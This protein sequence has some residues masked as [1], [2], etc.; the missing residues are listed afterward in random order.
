MELATH[1][2]L[3][4]FIQQSKDRE[5]LIPEKTIWKVLVQILVGLNQIRNLGLLHCDL[6]PSNVLLF[7]LFQESPKTMKLEDKPKFDKLVKLCDFNS[8]MKLKTRFM[9]SPMTTPLYMSPDSIEGLRAGTAHDLWSLG[10]ILYEMCSLNLPFE[11]E[12][13]PSLYKNICGSDYPS[14]P[15]KYSKDLAELINSLLKK[16]PSSRPTLED[17]L[18]NNSII[19]KV[20][21]SLYKKL[22]LDSFESLCQVRVTEPG[23]AQQQDLIFLDFLT[24]GKAGKGTGIEKFGFLYAQKYLNSS[25]KSLKPT[26]K[27]TFKAGSQAKPLKTG[28]PLRKKSSSK[29]SDFEAFELVLKERTDKKRD[30]KEKKNPYY[31]SQQEDKH[32]IMFD[33]ELM[34]ASDQNLASLLKRHQVNNLRAKE[35]RREDRVSDN[36][37]EE[38]KLFLDYPL[39]N[40][41]KN[42]LSGAPSISPRF[43]FANPK[44]FDSDKKEKNLNFERDHN[45]DYFFRSKNSRENL[46][47]DEN[48]KSEMSKMEPNKLPVKKYL[49]TVHNYYESELVNID[50]LDGNIFDVEEYSKAREGNKPPSHQD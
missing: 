50:G 48:S 36:S 34:N 24:Q 47:R 18:K 15:S 7:D 26:S 6:K 27:K 49:P 14:I 11:S 3:H 13:L 42:G 40:K 25:K 35:F 37:K 16:S 30:S 43:G 8:V 17:L 29:E 21:Q 1:G 22:H 28:S 9:A 31:Q 23:P 10:V 20:G 44:L 45:L 4:E 32:L 5:E 46:A 33:S 19:P 38:Q 2:T 12:S 39:E 41:A